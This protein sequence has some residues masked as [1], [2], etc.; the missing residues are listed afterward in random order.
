[1][2]EGSV[3]HAVR[4]RRAAL[5]TVDIRERTAMDLGARRG[6]RLSAL[7]RAGQAK[8]PMAGGDEVLDDG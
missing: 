8:H 1:V 3:D 7:V 5:E 2:V 6:E 4:L